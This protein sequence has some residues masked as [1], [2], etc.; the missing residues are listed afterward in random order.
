VRGRGV[1]VAAALLVAVLALL[2]WQLLGETRSQLSE[3]ERTH[4]HA[5]F[6][7]A[8]RELEADVDRAHQVL[9]ALATSTALADLLGA[10]GADRSVD[11]SVYVRLA[12]EL[13]EL[14]S[15]PGVRGLSVVSLEGEPMLGFTPERPPPG[16]L[17]TT[18]TADVL[19]RAARSPG[20]V[21]YD[22]ALAT[23]KR[24]QA[25]VTIVKSSSATVTVEIDAKKS[26][27]QWIDAAN[28][29]DWA[30]VDGQGHALLASTP[31][32]AANLA[33]GHGQPGQTVVQG[34]R[35]LTDMEIELPRWSLRASVPTRVAGEVVR[36]LGGIL[37]LATVVVVLLLVIGL[38]ASEARARLTYVQRSL[39]ETERQE[40]F[41][42][43]MF[44]AIT[45]VLVVIDPELK[46]VRAN[47]VARELY[48]ANLVGRD[49]A[50][51]LAQRGEDHPRDVEALQAV[52]HSGQPQRAEVTSP[53]RDKVWA[54]AQFPI[55]GPG[56]RVQDV[57]EIARDV[58]RERLLQVQLVQS[59]KLSTLGEMAA[60]IA[61]EINNPLGVVSMF[62]QLLAEE[63]RESLGE[64]S[65]ALEKVKTIEEQTTNV[66]EIVKNLLRFARK[67]GGEKNRLDLNVPI[68]RALGIAE[69]QK[70][71]RR[72]E[73]VRDTATEPPPEIVG[74]EAQLAQVVLNLVVNARHAMGDGG[75]LTLSARR[76]GPDDADPD[77]RAFGEVPQ[78]AERILLSVADTG[79][80][81]ESAVVDR[82][83]E[84]F[85][86]TKPVGEGTG[87]G[88]SV[89]FGIVRDHGGCV[90]VDSEPGQGT[91]FTLDLPAA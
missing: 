53:G 81:I 25:A 88:L 59:E 27:D 29:G 4:K 83:F 47:R 14:G 75:Q 1:P 48:G 30:L 37:V 84:P 2:F 20:S 31:E 76:K 87:L 52:L 49:Y 23:G 73:V 17:L 44:D 74:D 78:A 39:A 64:D 56:G 57:V 58:S 65:P 5:T 89:S 6:S 61:H 69:H 45:D 9:R 33:R 10:L 72:F 15:L 22:L 8:S 66:G 38:G 71:H 3:G 18:T 42:Q 55:F 12:E 35:V 54:L 26:L 85:F 41:L 86:T 79:S 34:E 24:L 32:A 11:P 90:W 63:I 70:E 77:G 68:D 51:A 40:R 46:V 21:V 50:K 60:G 82:L 67:S 28:D 80:G 36:E 91:T 13:R 7:D 43:A 19:T 62:A 16:P